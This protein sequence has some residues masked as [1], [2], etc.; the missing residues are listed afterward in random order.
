MRLP[1]DEV[2]GKLAQHFSLSQE[3]SNV[4]IVGLGTTGF[5]VARFLARHHFRFAVADSRSNPPSAKEL[6][7]LFPETPFIGGAFDS[8]GFSA[9][10]HLVVS[11]GIA[12]TEPAIQAACANG[13]KIVSD[14]DLFALS[15][16][17]P[18]IA[19]TGS[20]GK[21]TV[22]TL[23]GHIGGAAGKKTAAGGNLG[24]AALDL[25]E[26]EAELYV[27]ELSS[28]QLERSSALNACAATVLNISAD[29]LDRHRTMEAYAEE[30]RKVFNGDGVMVLNADD[31]R[32]VG[33]YEP[34]RQT[35]WFSISK[36]TGFHVA[37]KEGIEY[38]ADEERLL[39]PCHD[40]PL[41]GR[42][43]IANVL[44]ALALGEAAGLGV[45]K[46]CAA[47]KDFR[48]LEHRMQKVARTA[49]IDWVNDSKATNIGACIAA[50]EGYDD[51]VILL[52]GGDAKG[53][54]MN[55]LQE[56]VRT[57][58]KGVI[59]MGKDAD[60]IDKALDGCVPTYHAL[61]ME[62]AV[63]K[64]GKLAN[65][66]DTVLLSPACSSLDQYK[67]YQQRGERFAGAVKALEG[68]EGKNQK[69]AA[70]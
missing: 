55:E 43:N 32:V 5:S 24:T 63:Q 14:I 45:E 12:L 52:A 23:L 69:A 10:T 2:L 53:A 21:S 48:G 11:P 9:F 49:G 25:L 7:A 22:T 26:Q 42:H 58:A 33:M 29:H 41:E 59:L 51:K 27:L 18:V 1:D 30:K 67:N 39:M 34:Q 31:D 56:T 19:V 60:L 16:D 36:A 8:P 70:Y 54:D 50:L 20:N 17:A 35:R 38:L 66:G 13:A 64:A 4:L 47:L 15:T 57:K 62:Q 65:R 37:L 46:M 61:S 68:E 3:S 28:F 44:A 40:L 6:S